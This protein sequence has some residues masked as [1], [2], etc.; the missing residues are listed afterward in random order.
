MGWFDG[1][2]ADE[3]LFRRADRS[4]GAMPLLFSYGTL[5]EPKYQ[6]SVFGRLLS[7]TP[8][9]L[10]GYEP[11]LVPI[12]DPAVRAVTGR[13][14]HANVVGTERPESTVAGMALDVSEAELALA[15]DFERSADYVRVPVTLA[16]G[17]AAWMY[18][19]NTER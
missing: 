3:N 19:K 2:T 16:S 15:D 8:D 11:A 13:T 7:G 5:Q 4:A 14:H 12:E 6:L 10:P 1:V 18:R 17:R 9:A